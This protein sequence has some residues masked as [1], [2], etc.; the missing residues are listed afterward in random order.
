MCHFRPGWADEGDLGKREEVGR[1]MRVQYYWQPIFSVSSPCTAAT[2]LHSDTFWYNTFRLIWRLAENREQNMRS[3]GDEGCVCVCV[4]FHSSYMTG[5]GWRL[6][7]T[8]AHSDSCAASAGS[9]VT[10]QCWECGGG[11]TRA[12][13]LQP[14]WIST[15]CWETKFSVN[16][17]NGRCPSR[18]SITSCT[19]PLFF[20]I[21]SNILVQCTSCQCYSNWNTIQLG[22][23]VRQ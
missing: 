21:S 19:I 17:V 3:K 9:D 5:R 2:G 20:Y 8:E 18:I 12:L 10:G 4:S 6:K 1:L 13:T 15:E 14:C 23:V 16:V 22:T 11:S 7:D